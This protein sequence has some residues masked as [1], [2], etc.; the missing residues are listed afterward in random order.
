MRFSLKLLMVSATLFVTAIHFFSNQNLISMRSSQWES[1]AQTTSAP[2]QSD[3]P[4]STAEPSPSANK[5]TPP[6]HKP[7]TVIRKSPPGPVGGSAPKQS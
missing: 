7:P 4:T 2:S 6:Q 1:V 5:A 3:T